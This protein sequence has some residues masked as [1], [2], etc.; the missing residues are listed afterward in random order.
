MIN[1]YH[2]SMAPPPV[3]PRLHSSHGAQPMLIPTPLPQG[4]SKTLIRVLVTVVLLNL[5]VTAVG[6]IYLYMNNKQQGTLPSSAGTG[7][8]VSMQT[9]QSSELIEGSESYIQK[10][11]SHSMQDT[12]LRAFAQMTVQR[13]PTPPKSES[14]HLQWDMKDSQ[15]SYPHIN[16]FNSSW[17]T[18]EKSGYYFVYSRVTFSSSRSTVPLTN[19]V[20]LRKTKSDKNKAIMKAYCHLDQSSTKSNVCTATTEDVFKLEKG[21]QLS[22]WTE[23][24]S[25]VDYDEKAT[26]FGLYTIW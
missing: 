16:Y 26:V 25:L 19:M 9:Q 5:L 15:Y 24:K 11:H 1:T 2:T 23:D 21:N 12:S 17:V 13:P 7:P 20:M 4:P 14:G 6:I 22:V 10:H 8:Q 3:P 18:I